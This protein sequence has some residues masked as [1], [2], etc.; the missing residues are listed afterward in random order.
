MDDIR[1]VIKNSPP[2]VVIQTLRASLIMPSG[3]A[4]AIVNEL[5]R[6]LHDQPNYIK[7][8]KNQ[9]WQGA[10]IMQDAIGCD[11]ATAIER[12]KSADIV[13]FEVHGGG[14]RVGSSTMYMDS[15][16][17]WIKLF[18]TK[19]NVNA[20][21]MSID[22]GLS[23]KYKYP[24]PV[25]QS[26]KAF[27]YLTKILCVPPS[28]IILS[29]DSAGGA[30]CLETLIRTYAPNAIHDLDAPRE[31][32]DLDIPAGILLS[33]PLVSGETDSISW[34]RFEK[35]DMVSLALAEMVFKDFLGL[36]ETDPDDL[37]L[38]KLGKIKR[39]F[40][41]FCPKHALVLVGSREC[42]R[43]D[44]VELASAVDRDGGVDIRLITEDYAHDWFMIHEVIPKRDKHIIDY[45]DELFVDFAVEAV[46]AGVE[47]HC[48]NQKRNNPTKNNLTK[49]AAIEDK[50]RLKASMFT[51][52]FSL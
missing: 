43:D 36:P 22:Y 3:P 44:V 17:N 9:E 50:N 48:Q 51:L 40:R 24:V 42:L 7:K 34:K 15:F 13:I 45:Y 12:L 47:K 19:N 18:K 1:K 6:P 10:L 21:I 25:N 20:C 38:L 27:N 23:P 28:K 39:N 8:I 32:Y 26:I 35:T 52:S 30:I 11:E 14:F 46:Q 29:G 4:R 5:T 2:A 16:I 33:S 49:V 31:N 37:P 41:R